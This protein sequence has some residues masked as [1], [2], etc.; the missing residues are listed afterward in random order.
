AVAWYEK[1]IAADPAYAAPHAGLAD[2]YNQQGTV[3]IGN[4]SPAEGRKR[5]M[6]AARRALEIDPDL[7]EAHAALAYSNVCEWSWAAAEEGFER[8]IRLN[9][10]YPFAHLWLAHYHTAR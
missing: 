9:P 5:A 8:A 2:C 3:M 1:A 6:A 7:A 10:N 4:R